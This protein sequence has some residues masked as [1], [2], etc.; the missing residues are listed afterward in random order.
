MG[1]APAGTECNETG[2]GTIFVKAGEFGPLYAEVRCWTTRPLKFAR[3]GDVLIC[4][5]GAT[6]G[7]LNLAIDSAIGRSVAAIRPSEQL[8]T[9]FLYYSLMP[10]TLRLRSASRGS[11]QGVIGRE[12]LRGI[13]IPIPPVSEQR[14][15]VAKV[16]ELLTMCDE[17]EARQT[18][19]REHRTRLVRSSF[20]H[21]TGPST[22][23]SQ[24]STKSDHLTT[25]NGA[26]VCDPQ[27]VDR[28]TAFKNSNITFPSERC[29]SQSRAPQDDFR[30]HAAFV[31]NKFPHL[32]A[33]P[34]DVSA[35]RQ[36]VLSLAVQGHIVPQNA[37]DEPASELLKQISRAR[38]RLVAQEKLG[39]SSRM[40][41]K[42]L[43][44]NLLPEGWVWSPFGEVTFCRDGERIPVNSDERENLAKTYDYY[45]ASGVIDKID[46]YLFDTPLL[47]IGEDGANL[48]NRSTPI[49]F[50]AEGKYWV[51]NH[52]HV[53]DTIN[54]T[55]MEY[56]R[57]YINSINLE[58]YITGM[59]QPKMNQGQMNS[60][61]IALPPLAEQERIVAKV[62]E[63]LRWCD[64]LEAR[65]TAARTTA[66]HLL[67]AT[68][69]QILACMSRTKKH[70]NYGV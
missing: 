13:N 18:A 6:V 54:R 20:S 66:T 17:L 24:P 65:L 61:P 35:L 29:G 59:A 64:A 41:I 11:A 69:H 12:E 50:I 57:I 40:K 34:E 70:T 42:E 68:L 47:L 10:F 31:L 60:I 38:E 56:L 49:A 58:G 28:K 45:G 55:L 44:A 52:A 67:D 8:D 16:E 46:R 14:R 27:H 2:E 9:R 23:N 53:L 32:T 3:K 4:V 7:K 48:I 1:Q 15:I 21:L 37:K 43:P 63:L 36:A 33:A 51:N 39:A 19:A 62:D 26:R 22:L 5:V 30:R 25:P